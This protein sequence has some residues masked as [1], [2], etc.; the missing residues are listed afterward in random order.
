MK[1]KTPTIQSMTNTDTADHAKTAEQ[2]VKLADAGAE[3]VRITVNNDAAAQAI[4]KIREILNKKGYKK[5]PLIGDFHYNGY[6]LLEKFPKTAKILDKYRINP[7][8]EPNFE[9]FIAVAIKNNKPVRIGVNSGSVK[10][11]S[12]KNLVKIALDSAT[13]AEKLGLPAKNIYL[14][15]KNS[16]VQETIRAYELL[17]KKIKTRPYKIH[18]GLT[19]A[20]PG[21]QGIVASTAALAILLQ[22][23]I[24]DTIRVSLTPKPGQSRTRE[25]EIAQNLLQSLG[26]RHFRPQIASC[27]GCGRTDNKF[28]Q[29]I[30]KEISDYIKK[31]PTTHK[32]IAIMG[33][34][35]NGPGEARQADI[36]L[37]LP[38][39]TEKPIAQ[40]YI[41]G[42]FHKNL[43]GNDIAEQFIK[44]ISLPNKLK[45]YP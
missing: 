17:A 43:T 41:K 5:L 28:F 7:S 26:L 13:Q 37:I 4:P 2:C 31:N 36:A 29:K 27:P 16:D 9:K 42:R 34:T 10:N 12:P 35:V 40:V 15:V 44:L 6:K 21:T 11:P 38:G 1:L 19:E 22:K 8:N 3:M 24:G 23:G 45:I 33:C 18:L 20:G 32:K 14:S 25:V 39:K 30:T